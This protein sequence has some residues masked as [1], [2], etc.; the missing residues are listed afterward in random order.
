MN[1]LRFS[2][3][4]RGHKLRPGRYRLQAVPKLFGLAGNTL[5]VSFTI[6]R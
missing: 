2:G 1:R 5:T 3:R 4:I 6:V